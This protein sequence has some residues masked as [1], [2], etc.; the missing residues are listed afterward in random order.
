MQVPA[1]IDPLFDGVGEARQRFVG[2]AD[3]LGVVG[4]RDAVLGDEDGDALRHL[5]GVAHGHGE[6]VGA[7]GGADEGVVGVRRVR[8]ETAG[9]HLLA[10]VGL[11]ADE[12]VAAAAL[13]VDV[14]FAQADLEQLLLAAGGRGQCAGAMVQPTL[15]EVRSRTTARAAWWMRVNM[16]PSSGSA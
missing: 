16:R 7:V 12:V 13:P 14:L 2:V 11:D 5:P 1:H 4:G 3:A 9:V 15:A 8:D 6:C 10:G